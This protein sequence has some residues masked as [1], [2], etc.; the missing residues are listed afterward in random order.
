[1]SNTIE[2]FKLGQYTVKI[3][4]DTDPENPRTEW[5][6]TFKMACFH[7]RYDMPN[8]DSITLEKAREIATDPDYVCFAVYM[9]DHSGLSFSM[10]DFGD[11]WDSGQVGIIY[12]LRADLEKAQIPELDDDYANSDWYKNMSRLLR[13]SAKSTPFYWCAASEVHEYDQY[14]RGDVY[15]YV[16]EDSNGEQVESCWQCFGFDY[17][18]EAAIEEATAIINGEAAGD[19]FPIDYVNACLRGAVA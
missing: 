15:G 19:L 12:A 16:I 3:Y 13:V 14:A 9:L 7:D 1:M 8:D 18:K 5:A 4:Q 11:S 10:S 17:C 6:H 2:T